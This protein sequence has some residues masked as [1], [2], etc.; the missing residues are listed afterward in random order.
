LKP[1]G[2]VSSV[3]KAFLIIDAFK[4]KDELSVTE[5]SG[6]LGYYPSTVHRFLTTLEYFGY[7]EQN[8]DSG[9]Y[10]L[11][12]KLLE[13]GQL[14]LNRI[15]L[16]QRV[17]PV[18]KELANRS[19]ETANLAIFEDKIEEV[20]FIDQIESPRDIKMGLRVGRITQL[21]ATALGKVIFA[22]LPNDK[23]KELLHK[24]EFLKLTENTTTDPEELYGQL[25]IVR[26]SGFAI[27]N[28]EAMEGAKCIAAPLRDYTGVVVAAISISAPAS[29]ITD[30]N[31]DEKVELVKRSA[32]EASLNLGY[33]P[34]SENESSVLSSLKNVQG[35]SVR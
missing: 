35:L 16:R 14:V 10:K 23:I 24:K 12:L 27:D 28:E 26:Q 25:N 11:G 7:V 21:H 18:L 1:K 13:L 29:R 5:L 9:K 3:E 19:G 4:K 20:V 2:F 30:E 34:T 32:L 6:T 15:D 8:P 22:H 31:I 17:R 33:R